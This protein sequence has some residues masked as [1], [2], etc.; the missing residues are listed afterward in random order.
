MMSRGGVA[1]DT[2][3]DAARHTHC[4]RAEAAAEK[5]IAP[6]RAPHRRLLRV[7]LRL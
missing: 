1:G 6:R 4:H 7:D 5:D 3:R 2:R